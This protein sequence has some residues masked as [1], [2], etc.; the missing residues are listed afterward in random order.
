[1]MDK[2][3]PALGNKEHLCPSQ[4]VRRDN[5]LCDMLGL[6]S[7]KWGLSEN[8]KKRCSKILSPRYWPNAITIAVPP[9]FQTKMA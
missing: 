1:M 3:Q 5:Q 6:E 8:D 2:L 4:M 7:F 9:A